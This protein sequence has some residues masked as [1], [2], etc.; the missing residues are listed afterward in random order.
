MPTGPILELRHLQMIR[1]I[2][3]H[4]RVTDAAE[5][6]GLT[7]SALSHRIREAERRLDIVLFSRLHK[8]LRMTPAAEYLADVAARVLTD[9]ERAEADV[10][11]MNRGVDH[12][13]RIAV[14][15]YSAYYWLPAF[16]TFLRDRAPGIDLQVMAAAGREPLQALTNRRVDLVIVSGDQQRIGVHSRFLFDDELLFIMPPSHRHADKPFITG[17][18]IVGEDF[19]TY[20]KVPE[21]DREFARL[22]RPAESYP[23]WTATV[24]LPEAIVELVA[25][26]QGTS[27]L[28]GW[29]V[30]PAIE[31]GRIA[32]TRVGPDGLSVPWCAVLRGEDSQGGPILEIAE[33]MADWSREKGGIG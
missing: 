8:R 22:F 29:A 15:A 5:A 11:R 1:A 28:A 17:L 13:V 4:G 19:I 33:A 20:T 23:R 16:L 26:G 32:A 9:I 3:Q 7:P 2:A 27:V 6:L 18:D 24:E 30:R 31:A 10:R 14:E 12:V 25:A 21:P